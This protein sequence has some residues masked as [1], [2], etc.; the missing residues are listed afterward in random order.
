[1]YDLVATNSTL[2]GNEVESV[3]ESKHYDV[4]HVDNEFVVEDAEDSG[5]D[6]PILRFK[7]TVPTK[8]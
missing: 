1:M 3:R 7:R 8:P 5:E 2:K 6:E 4:G